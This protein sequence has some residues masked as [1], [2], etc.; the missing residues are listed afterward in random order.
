MRRCSKVFTGK[1]IIKSGK[2]DLSIIKKAIIWGDMIMNWT[3]QKQC[4][5]KLIFEG[6]ILKLLFL[7]FCLRNLKCKEFKIPLK[8]PNVGV[9]D[10]YS[11]RKPVRPFFFALFVLKQ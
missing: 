9:L 6:L 2:L 5:T 7:T 1:K 3:Q 4:N 11:F 10:S 8:N